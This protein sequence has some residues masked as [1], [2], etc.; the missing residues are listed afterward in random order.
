MI[1]KKL[2]HRVL[3]M[4]MVVGLLFT[5][6]PLSALITANASEITGFSIDPECVA[7]PGTAHT[8]ET[9][10]GTDVD[11]NRYSGRVWADKSVF[12]DGETALLNTKGTADS[13]FKVELNADESFQVV[14]SVLGSTMTTKET[15]VSSGPMDVVLVLDTSTSMDDTD[16]DGVTRLERTIAAS[17]ALLKDLLNL[18]DVRIAIVTYNRDSE[19]VLPLA[20]YDN[21]VTLVVT[22]YKNV[23]KPDAGVVTAYD[24]DGRK[25]GSDSGYT[26]GTNL[27]AGIERGFNILANATDAEGRAPVAIVLTDGEANRAC[28]E[29][30][31]ELTDSDGTSA[32]GRNLYLSTLLNAAYNKTKIENHYG[33]EATVYTVG[34]DITTNVTAR[35]LMNPADATNGFNANNSNNNVKRAYEMFQNWARGN[36]VSYDDWT[37][38]HNYPKQDGAMTDAKIAANIYYADAYYD[39]SS[40]SLQDTFEQIYKELSSAAFNPISSSTSVDGGTG[41]EHT[42]LIYVDFIGQHMEIK[43]IQAITLFGASY[44]VEENADGT[45][46]VAEATGTNPT[47]AEQWNTAE[48]IRISVTEQADGTQ[49]LEIRIDQE[50]LPIILEQVVSDTVGNTTT[51]TITE[52]L[53]S[54]LRVYYTVGLDSDILLPNGDIDATKLQ[55]YAYLN[56]DGTA[57]FYSNRFG[58]ENA[59]NNEGVVMNGDAHVGF[60]PSAENRYYF[61]QTNQGIFTKITNKKTGEEV[62]ISPNEEFGILWDAD[63]YEL[64]WMSYEQYQNMADNARVY[65]YVTYYRP[66][67]ST[68]DAAN[69]AEQV[70]YLVY[71]DWYHLKESVTFYDNTAKV[72]LNDGKAIPS[73]QVAAV[74]AAYQQSNPRAD[75]YAVLGINSLRTSRLH[76]MTVD[77]TENRT[78]TAVVRYAPEYTHER[79]ADHNDNSVVVWLGN[80]G[81]LTAQI[82][83]GIAL[84]KEVTEPIGNAGDT[85]TLTVTVPEGVVAEPAVVDKDGNAVAFT[86]SNNVLAVNLKAGETVYISGIPAGT[87]CVIGEVI[88]EGAK[89][90]VSDNTGKVTVPTPAQVLAGEVAQYVVAKVTNAP[91]KDGNLYITKEINSN[92]AIPESVLNTPFEITVHVGKE[93]AG[94]TFTVKDSAQADAYEKTVDADGNMAFSIKARQTIE[95][96]GLPVGTVA[97]VTETTPDAHFAVS[98]RSRDYSGADADSDNIVTIPEGANSTVV[99]LNAYTP[100]PVSVDLDIVGTKNFTAEGNHPGGKFVYKVQQR[101]GN[102]WVDI[103]GKTAETPYEDNEHGTKTF[104]IEDV[105]SGITYT[106]VGSYAYQ[107]LEVKGDV[108]NVTYD[109]TL[110]S[111]TVTVTDNG[112]QLVATVTDLKNEAITDGTYEVVFNNTYHTAPVSM[113]ITKVV[114]NKSGD[115]TVTAQGFKFRSIPVD[116]NGNPLSDENPETGYNTIYTDAAGNARINGV[117]TQAGT[118][119]YIVYEESADKPGWTYSGAEYLIKVVVTDDGTGN[120]TAVMEITPWNDAARNETAPVVTENNKGHLYF[121][122][123]Y[124][125]ED[126]TIDLD[127]KVAKELNGKTLEAN[128]FTFYVYKDG[129]RTAPILTGTND[130]DGNVS[131]M[132]F[133]NV[134]TFDKVGK[135]SYDIVEGVP[136]GATYD[137]ASGRYVLNGMYYDPTVYDLVIEV[138]NDPATGKLVATSYFEDAT[139]DVVTFHNFYRAEP[140]SY[141]LGGNKVLTGRAV[142]SGEFKFQLY[143][144][145]Q[146]LDE[147]ENQAGGSFV[148]DPIHYT[149]PGVYT[150]TIVEVAG[151]VPGVE[152]TGVNNPV[153]VT[154]TVTDNNGVLT[155]T[156]S[157]SNANVKF[158]NAYLA[159]PAQ[160]SFS[161]TK[162][163]VGA[164]LEDGAFTF[165]LY[166]TDHNFGISEANLLA[167]TTNAGTAFAFGVRSIDKTGTYYFTIIEDATVNTRDDLVYDST[168]HNYIVYVTDNGLGQL[169]AEVQ[170]IN[171]GSTKSGTAVAVSASFTNAHEDEVTEKEVYHD[172]DV[173]TEIDG[174]KVNVGD[175]L[176]Y[177]ISYTNYTGKETTVTINDVIPE[178][179]SYV[180]GTAS[181]G[182]VYAG[183]HLHWELIVPAGGSVTVSF[184]VVVNSYEA[185]FANVATVRDGQNTYTT[186]EVTNYTVE[187]V[188]TKDVFDPEDPEVSID[189]E[190]VYAGDTL[191]YVITYTNT[192]A[193]SVDI[194]I[195]DVIP[196]FTTYVE[197]SATNG[198]VYADGVLTWTLQDVA[199]WSTVEVAFDVIVDEDID[200]ETIENTAQVYDGENTYETKPVT[201]YTVVDEVEKTV[202]QETDPDINIDGEKVYSGDVLVYEISYKNTAQE[203]ATVTITDK[204]P[205]YTTYVDG[206]VT[207]DGVYADGVITWNLEVAAGETVTVSFKVTVNEDIGAESI[208]NQATIVEGKNEYTTEE[209]INYTTADEVDKDVF[210]ASEPTVSIDGDKVRS[211]ETLLYAVSYKNT[212]RKSV[213]VTITDAIPEFTTYVDGSASDDGVY[214][215]GVITWTIEVGAGETATVTF[216]VTVDEGIGAQTIV[217]SAKLYEGNNAYTTREVSNYTVVDEVGKT[218]Y[219]ESDPEINIDGKKVYSGDVLVYEISYKNTAKEPA[220]VTI[221]DTIPAYTTY[222]EGSATNGGVYADGVIT[223]ILEVEAGETVTV[224]FKVTVN[225]DIGAEEIANEAVIVDGNNKYTT[226]AVSNYTTADEVSKDVYAEED[227][228]VSIDGNKVNFGD[229]LIYAVTYKN[230]AKE[231]VTVTI[232]DVIP[233]HTEYV[234]GSASH[235]GVYA[236]GV[237][238]WN[239]EVAAGESITVTFKV[240]VTAKEP[241]TIVNQATVLEGKNEYTTNEVTNYTVVDEV[242]KNV[243][244]Q[245]NPYVSINGRKVNTGDIL[246]YEI[247]YKNN[248]KESVTV[249]I[250]DTIPMYTAYVEGSASHG[251]IYSN[252]TITWE[253]EVGAGETVTVSF[254][255]EVV[256]EGAHVIPNRATILE[257]D[258]KYITNEVV[259]YTTVDEVEKDVY[260]AEKPGVSIDGDKVYNG[261]TLVYAITY[262]NN[263]LERVTVTITDAIPAFTE[264]VEG[265]ASHGGVYA[266][267]KL[268]WNLRVGAGQSVTVTFKVKVT[269]ED[270]QIIT[271]QATVVEGNHTYITNEV[272]NYTVVDEVEKNVFSEEDPDVTIDGRKVNVGDVL[273]YEIT[274]KNTAKE[275]AAVTITDVVPEHTAYVEGSAT[276]G[277]VYADGVV[278]WNLEVAAGESVT[279][280]FCVEVTAEGAQVIAN[281][282]TILEGKNAYTTN[283]TVNYTTVDEVGK[284]VYFAKNPNVS[285]NG[286]KVNVGDILVYAITYKNTA[287]EGVSITITDVIPEHTAYVEGSATNGGVYADGVVTWN[288]EVGA[289]ETVTVYFSVEVIAEGAQTIANQATILEGSNK[290]TTNEVTNYT[291]VDEVE[292]EVFA[293]DAP[294]VNIDGKKVNVGDILVYTITYKNTA[295]ESA[296]VT[297]TDRIPEHTVYVEGSASNGGTYEN[298]VVLWILEVGAGESVTVSFSVEVTAEGAETIANEATILEGNNKY[299]TNEVTNYTTADEVEKNVF[300]EQDPEVNIDGQQV[301]VGDTLVYTISYK[302][303]GKESVTVTIIDTIPAHTT[304]VEGSASHGGVYEDG[305]ITWTLEVAAGESVTVSFRVMVAE[306]G[307]ETIANKATVLEGENEYTTN[308]VTNEIKEPK[309]DDSPAT[310][311]IDLLPLLLVLIASGCGLAVVTSL[312]K[313]RYQ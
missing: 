163:L 120:L 248:A 204:I 189:G 213:M 280:S 239:L 109:R 143:A 227:P 22:E 298:G 275:S 78:E 262:K 159:Q 203:S 224:S 164:D 162:T 313:K 288:L 73:D 165:K 256:T 105:L 31:Y 269:A 32:S 160:V 58:V 7:D 222:V 63:T 20:A 184:D 172:G 86:Y 185:I 99:V 257:G 276:N 81:K 187:D 182:G 293:A 154:V 51:A 300:V 138:E 281:T 56:N 190:K 261:D 208:A 104:I 76:N 167:T 195:T 157:L 290:Y 175:I 101:V 223:W 231:S 282:A 82:H 62:T 6:I 310:G 140:T 216:E 2:L 176:T 250:L 15:S 27:Q 12:T 54:P 59:A 68:S 181:H 302:N 37:F 43:D 136:T 134:M 152:Y 36:N 66:T 265:S 92:H 119:Y 53:Q 5:S 98:Y 161:G 89:Y 155:A 259:N 151:D 218:V 47:T 251:G 75:L 217:N 94:E 260:S 292:K 55:G 103:E 283:E 246:V 311:D 77:K 57:T 197:G 206:S 201:N 177:F 90:V 174:K 268:T 180:E 233:E 45:Y 200:A 93:L 205:A 141:V 149:E 108:A 117:Y 247:S 242:Q 106:E 266:D 291:V 19:T 171:T 272:E 14:F 127:G 221:T 11:G 112:G 252:G 303:T 150:Y 125:P 49:K 234:E 16:E 258:N 137:A 38:D 277:G 274:Y 132:D 183:T 1:K 271:N 102:E 124:D 67:T 254:C 146:L 39:V 25:L 209:V 135:Y 128:Q 79:A 306:E 18:H 85:Y 211:G 70:T 33:T 26:M 147:A 113:D 88:P 87:E 245:S 307:G 202:Y 130:L 215:S 236:D 74:V 273:V 40:A 71:A 289:G 308:E 193:E 80:N 178:H 196:E 249:T 145:D 129:D 284:D 91:I 295:K 199:A 243:Y 312:Y 186:N 270:A 64:T 60:Q 30:F 191:H 158:E 210:Y 13:S 267:G 173:S 107:V 110:Y 212:G 238:T 17:N 225:E 121:T 123:T 220:T 114:E 278:T 297:I 166:A 44:N 131:F 226:N 230:T 305:E 35:L 214:D 144:G 122:N 244:N 179:T 192:S 72:Y 111:F 116:E 170:H 21:G 96:L 148:F 28:E 41:V 301:N 309:E 100:S 264:Y 296:T 287:K 229:T 294:T 237:L 241:Q 279:V 304:Y 188:V 65:R 61:N 235:D 97:T 48:A 52:V 23:D 95:I 194:T 133:D 115:T 29:G 286:K 219:Q 46:T 255:A 228:T 126:V 8:W 42:P 240:K 139:T 9:M 285:I 118:Y 84:T 232:T 198:G 10:M 168:A 299:T 34:V 142:K 69:A 207:N 24:N 50:I 156:A 153:T 253:L 263:A 4:L 83:T 3:S 169:V